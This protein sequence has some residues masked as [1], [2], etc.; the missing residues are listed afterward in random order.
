MVGVLGAVVTA[1]E[2]GAVTTLPL[3]AARPA[4]IAGKIGLSRGQTLGKIAASMREAQSAK[5]LCADLIEE[6]V[7]FDH[8][9][10]ALIGPMHRT[11][12]EA[13]WTP[14]ATLDSA[15]RGID[16]KAARLALERTLTQAQ[17]IRAGD[18]GVAEF[19]R[20]VSMEMR[21]YARPL[22]GVDARVP[23]STETF[24][25]NARPSRG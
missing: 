4:T 25:E 19:S 6:L 15:G 14:A 8:E 18:G 16:D 21:S 7:R 9:P 24:G 5:A 20:V 12:A 13:R 17:G 3:A 1:S 22:P 23:A 10:I 2:L 11:A